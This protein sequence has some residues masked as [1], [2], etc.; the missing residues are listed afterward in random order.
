MLSQLPVVVASLRGQLGARYL[1]HVLGS[2]EGLAFLLGYLADVERDE[3][4]IFEELLSRVPDERFQKMIR[5]HR[6]DERRHAEVLERCASSVGPT[7]IRAPI[8]LNMPYR[9]EQ[10]L[11][12]I[13]ESF[14]QGTCGVFEIYALL[15]V[16]EERAVREYPAMI[17]ALE[18]VDSESAEILRQILED[19]KRHVGYARAIARHFAPSPAAHDRTLACFR[20]VEAQVF[21][22][23]GP[24]VHPV[25]AR[26]RLA[27]AG[28]AG[29]EPPADGVRDRSQRGAPAARSP[30]S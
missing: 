30:E 11:C 26:P 16:L 19:E 17:K 4:H 20:A 13:T 15:Q 25:P 29:V 23:E 27:R 12:G 18:R 5:I 6:D 21:E 28:G 14:L 7:P 22:A 24:G 9:L 3:V 2:L 1:N 10:A 8:E